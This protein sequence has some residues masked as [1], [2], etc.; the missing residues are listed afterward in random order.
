MDRSELVIVIPAFREA[1]T[2]G[3][4]VGAVTDLARVVVV[5]DASGDTTGAVA[6]NAGAMLVK[7][8]RNQG[9]EG[10]LNAGFKAA[11]GLGP[12]AIL[13]MDADGEHGP[14]HVA[15]FADL[16]LT[17][18]FPLVLGVR[19]QTQRAAEAA[20]GAYTK[21]RFGVH[22]IFCGMK[23]YHAS[24]WH[25]HGCF[26]S[27]QGV[28]TE[29]A[30]AAIRGGVPFEEVEIFGTPRAGAP[31]FDSALRANLRILRAVG[32][33]LSVPPLSSAK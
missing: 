19:V 11:A 13:T 27:R 25:R 3:H 30:L 26:D 8:G 32:R 9:Y 29:L 17:Q 4:V 23:G 18:N 31:R 28:G 2:I 22:D 10:A 33:G 16:L 20:I 15:T 7:N 6:Q 21:W 24:L 14:E 1:S 12:R 5:D